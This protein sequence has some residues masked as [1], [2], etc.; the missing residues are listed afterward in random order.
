[1]TITVEP[2]TKALVTGAAGF[3]G[4]HLVQA[5]LDRGYEVVG[6]DRRSPRSDALARLHL[7][8][9]LGHPRLSWIEGDLRELDVEELVADI[10]CVFHLAAVPGVRSS[11]NG[12][13]D[14]VA[15]NIVATERLLNAC[16]TAG[17]P[18]LVYASS[19]SVNGPVGTPSGENDPT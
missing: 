8:D 1:M 12:F 10:G 6:I 7:R 3:I 5:L 14:Y 18:K 9:V 19:S 17:T 13:A 2:G 15:A 4:S 11:W 16:T